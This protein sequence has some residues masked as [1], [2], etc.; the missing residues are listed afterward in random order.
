[1]RTIEGVICRRLLVN[2][3]VD[4]EVIRPLVPGRFEIATVGGA[5]IAGVCL[6]RLEGMHPNAVHLVPIGLASDNAAYRVAVTWSD[7]GVQR[8][9]VFV[10]R[11]DSSS[12]L[13]SRLGGWLFPG[14][15]GRAAFDVQDD[16]HHVAISCRSADGMGDL[17]IEG[18]EGDG[19]PAMSVFRSVTSASTF[20]ERGSDGYSR[21]RDRYQLDGIRLETE[22][23]SVRPFALTSVSSAFFDDRGTFPSGSVAFD[24]ALVMRDVAHAWRALPNLGPATVTDCTTSAC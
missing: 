18:R 9:G 17:S 2:F 16:G 14:D 12:A 22:P 8:D 10:L 4:P 1:M 11:R 24:N 13:Q 7:G 6:I 15:Y 5:A 20:F 19:M 23:W 21:S 3:R